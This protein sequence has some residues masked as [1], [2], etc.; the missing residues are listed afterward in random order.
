MT[1]A[2]YLFAAMLTW[3][4]LGWHDYTR[5]PRTETLARYGSIASDLADVVLDPEEVP[6]FDG[7][8]GRAQTAVLMLSIASYESG[9]FRADVD[10]QDKPTGDGGHAWCLGQ[11]HGKYAEGLTDRQSCFRGMLHAL[12]D[13]WAMCNDIDGW[14]VAYHLTGYT[15]GVCTEDEPEAKHRADR[16]MRWWANAPWLPPVS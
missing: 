1:I 9:G 14:D 15:V 8:T 16:A 3:A 10:R 4:P 2:P 13:S 12:R 6:L 5:I 11:L 7:P